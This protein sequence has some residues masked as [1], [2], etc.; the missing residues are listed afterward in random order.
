M[1]GPVR[2]FTVTRD[3]VLALAALGIAFVGH[4]AG[5]GTDFRKIALV[6]KAQSFLTRAIGAL[7]QIW[8]CSRGFPPI[9]FSAPSGDAQR[10]CP[11]SVFRQRIVSARRISSARLRPVL[12][13]CRKNVVFSACQ[14]SVWRSASG[15]HVESDDQEPWI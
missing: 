3:T 5:S 11:M 13:S 15:S 9:A 2:R 4:Q 8:F 14:E 6:R 12:S 7:G 1:R 10:V